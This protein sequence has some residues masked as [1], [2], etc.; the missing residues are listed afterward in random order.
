MSVYDLS[1]ELARAL[2]KSE[3][4][5]RYQKI[6]EKVLA[7]KD[8]ARM[9]Q[10]YLNLRM[11]VNSAQLFGQEADTEV[12]E[13]LQKLEEL[14]QLNGDIQTYLQAEMQ[15]GIL[16]QDVQRIITEDLDLGLE[17]EGEES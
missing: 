8:T 4:Y 14:V 2:K 15:M 16:L 12:Q 5:E 11:K 9:V 6:R 3:E 13:K 1:H 10:D 7:S 17:Q